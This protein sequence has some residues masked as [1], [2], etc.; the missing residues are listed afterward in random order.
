MARLDIVLVV[1]PARKE[2]VDLFSAKHFEL[3]YPFITAFS[4]MTY[5]YSSIQRPGNNKRFY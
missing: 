3:L 4:L 1:P 5:D 2:T